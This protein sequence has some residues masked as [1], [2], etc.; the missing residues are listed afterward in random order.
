MADCQRWGAQGVAEQGTD[1]GA[2]IQIHVLV[3]S[4][5][6]EKILASM[7]RKEHENGEL[8]SI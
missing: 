2:Y 1:L 5:Q 4:N 8:L 6:I 7:F 3:S